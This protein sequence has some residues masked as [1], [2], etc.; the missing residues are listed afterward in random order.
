MAY[1][2]RAMLTILLFESKFDGCVPTLAVS[3]VAKVLFTTKLSQ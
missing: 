1:V 3:S 2:F